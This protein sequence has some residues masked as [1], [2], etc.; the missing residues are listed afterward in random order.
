MHI[1]DVENKED[2]LLEESLTIHFFISVRL[3][4]PQARCHR[5][6]LI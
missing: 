2:Y 6:L 3:K 5:V 4:R 1:D